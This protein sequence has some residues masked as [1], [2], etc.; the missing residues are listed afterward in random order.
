MGEPRRPQPVVLEVLFTSR[1]GSNFPKRWAN[2]SLDDFYVAINDVRPSLIRVEADEATY[3]LHILVR[4][5]LEQALVND[6]LQCADLPGAWNEKYQHYLGIAPPDDRQG[7]LQDIH[8]SAGLIGYFPTY[9]LGNLYAAQ[10]FEQANTDLGGLDRQFA[11]GNFQPLLNWLREKIH[12][13][14]QC[15]TADELV[16]RVTGQPLSHAPLMQHLRGKFGPLFGV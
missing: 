7:V 9:S 13:A 14:G 16:K 6:E 11:A 3:N 5:E 1:R 10:F 15:Y 2:V 12:R 8:W 4:F